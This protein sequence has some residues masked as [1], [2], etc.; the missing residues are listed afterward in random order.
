M[1]DAIVVERVPV[2]L[3]DVVD[4]EPTPRPA[5]D[6]SNRDEERGELRGDVVVVFP[7]KETFCFQLQL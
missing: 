4:V 2:L 5:R 7:D 3:P 1:G 6:L